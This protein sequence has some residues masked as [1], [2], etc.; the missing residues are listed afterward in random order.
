MNLSVASGEKDGE[1]EWL[2]SFV[3]RLVS[4]ALATSLV[5]FPAAFALATIDSAAF[6]T[7][8]VAISATVFAASL[9]LLLDSLFSAT[10]TLFCLPSSLSSSSF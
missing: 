9:G 5:T 4:L 3:S 6:I 8:S 2:E 10:L 1:D 7:A